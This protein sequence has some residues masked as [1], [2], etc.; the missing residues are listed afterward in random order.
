MIIIILQYKYIY[1]KIIKKQNQVK[2]KDRILPQT[3][4]TMKLLGSTKL[5]QVRMKIVKM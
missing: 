5:K 4:N 2:N 3:F 1:I